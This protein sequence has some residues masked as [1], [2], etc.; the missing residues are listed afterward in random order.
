MTRIVVILETT[1]G[2][3]DRA[4]VAFAVGRFGGDVRGYGAGE[5]TYRYL[6]AAGI[7]SAWLSRPTAID[8]QLALVGTCDD[9]LPAA[10][11]EARRG[12]LVLDVLDVVIADDHLLVTRDLGRG[13]RELLRVRG[14]AVLGLSDAAPSDLYVSRHRRARVSVPVRDTIATEAQSDWRPVRPRTR[15]A[16]IAAKTAGSATERSMAVF[17]LAEQQ[18]SDAANVLAADPGTCAQHLLRYLAHHGFIERAD[19]PQADDAVPLREDRVARADP[20]AAMGRTVDVPITPRI[21]RGPRP[22]HGPMPGTARRPVPARAPSV[23]EARLARGPRPVGAAV[24][25]NRRGPVPLR[26]D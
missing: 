21:A 26:N 7:Q 11:A 23:A 1:I 13:E 6:A 14:P 15:T 3:A 25:V 4:A 16:D 12:A 10:L 24:S 8:F 22:L 5:V 18:A 2:P 9:L 20:V 19:A 17:G